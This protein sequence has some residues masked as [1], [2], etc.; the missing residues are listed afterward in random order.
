MSQV[1]ALQRVTIG[2]T[3]ITNITATALDILNRQQ[4]YGPA[5]PQ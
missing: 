3:A 2:P 4:V 1:R 5:S